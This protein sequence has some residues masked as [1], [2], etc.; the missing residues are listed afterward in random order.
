MRILLTWLFIPRQTHQVYRQSH[1]PP[2]S[3]SG[4]DK[5]RRK[6]RP[7][8]FHQQY[9]PQCLLSYHRRGRY[10]RVCQKIL[11][12]LLGV[13]LAR[14]QIRGEGDISVEVIVGYCPIEMTPVETKR[15]KR[16]LSSIIL[17]N[18][19]ELSKCGRSRVYMH[20]GG[21]KCDRN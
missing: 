1:G 3:S 21:F 2:I 8:R 7:M 16:T 6:A 19:C 15:K 4:D 20:L 17:S 5:E 13:S 11:P 12:D 9:R 10:Y 14:G 18:G